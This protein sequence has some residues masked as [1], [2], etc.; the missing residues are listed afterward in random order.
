MAQPFEIQNRLSTLVIFQIERHVKDD[1]KRFQS[2]AIPAKV[3][4]KCQ[5]FIEARF[6]GQLR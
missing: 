1:V 2:F 5:L 6:V 3:C 4:L